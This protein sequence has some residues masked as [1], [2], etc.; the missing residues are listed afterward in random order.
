M[1][2]IFRYKKNKVLK[3]IEDNKLGPLARTLVSSLILF[4]G[5]YSL[6]MI[7]DFADNKILNTKEFRNDSK[8]VLAYT[9]D[10]QTSK[11]FEKDEAIQ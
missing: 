4:L 5:F 6:P 3:S 9:L 7:A 1:K 2:K 11:D 8:T 10:K